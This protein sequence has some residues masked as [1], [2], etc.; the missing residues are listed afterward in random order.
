MYGTFF[1]PAGERNGK[2]K[3]ADSFEISV[4][5]AQS[6]G[7]EP[8]VGYQPTH[9]F[10]SCALDHS[11]NSASSILCCGGST[12]TMIIITVCEEKVNRKSKKI[13]KF[14]RMK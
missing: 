4:L 10:Q 13:G 8:R 7:F 5:L 9:D 14:L 6:L 1:M 3:H 12:A 2:V 11:A